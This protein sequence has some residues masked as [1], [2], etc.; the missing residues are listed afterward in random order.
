MRSLRA[1]L[2]SKYRRGSDLGAG[3]ACAGGGAGTLTFRVYG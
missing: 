1:G 2:G 3:Q